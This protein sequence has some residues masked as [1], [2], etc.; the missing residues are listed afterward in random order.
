MSK[1]WRNRIIAGDKTFAACPPAYKA[2]VKALLK[3]D[4]ENG[5]ITEADYKKYTGEKYIAPATEGAE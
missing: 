5:V 2:G 3:K 4:V 1:I